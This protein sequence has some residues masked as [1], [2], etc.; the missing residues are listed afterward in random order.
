VQDAAAIVHK[1]FAHRLKYARIWG[2]RT[3]DGQMVQREH[4]LQDGDILELH[5]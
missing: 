1:D 2:E 5:A 4:V 3:F